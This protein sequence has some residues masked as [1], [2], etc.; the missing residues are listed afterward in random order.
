VLIRVTCPSC[1]GAVELECRGLDCFRVYET[2][3]EYTCPLCRKQGH[4][5]SPG[6]I[7]SVRIPAD[8]RA[9]GR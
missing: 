5:R 2:Y 1:Q 8:V 9:P 3:N 6:A 7:L 4:Q